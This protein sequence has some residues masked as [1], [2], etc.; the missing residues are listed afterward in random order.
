MPRAN[1]KLYNFRTRVW[2]KI[3]HQPIRLKPVYD[4][5]TKDPILTVVFL[6][7]ISATSDTW[8]TTIRQF[9]KNSDLKNIRFIAL[10]LLGFGAALQSKWLDY[11]Y[12]DYDR[13]LDSTLKHL[14]ITSPVVLIGHS[15]GSLI[16]AD[17]AVNF[18]PSVDLSH[19]ILVSPPI[20]LSEEL[21]KLPDRVYTKSYASLHK[22]AQAFGR[23]MDN[24]IL[25]HNN[26]RTFTKLRI[27]T[28]IIHGHFDP[29][30]IR[31][32]LKHLADVNSKYI[33]FI[34]VMGHHD[35]SA[36]KRSKILIELKKI[37]REEKAS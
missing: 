15:M 32:N 13:A 30:V 3:L 34:S 23:S 22:L 36:Q 8:R 2:Y 26:Y 1:S 18:Q 7:G 16:A 6:H 10:D 31:S 4:S 37:L 14:R 24:I 33:N 19:L 20:L 9:T 17:Y 5:H 21:A 27:P 35:I 28:L 29:L 12:D 11:D 25:N